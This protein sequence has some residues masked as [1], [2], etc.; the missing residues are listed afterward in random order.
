MTLDQLP[1]I[2]P[3]EKKSP[4]NQ[5]QLERSQGLDFDL[6]IVGGGIVGLT[7]ACALKDSGLR[8]ALIEAQSPEQTAARRQAYAMSLLSGRI[9]EG[10]GV[11]P[12]I[13]PHITHFQRVRLSDADY[14]KE[15]VFR[16]ED[17]KTK[18]VYYGAEHGVLI[19]ALQNCVRQCKSV[20]YLCPAQLIE[21]DYQP[22]AVQLKVQ[23]AGQERTLR[24]QLM[25]AADGARS[26]IRQQAGIGSMGWK[27]WQSCITAVLKP[28]KSHLDTAYERFWPD[29]PFAIL[30]L[31][32]NRCQIVWTVPHAKAEAILALP[33]EE[34]LA[35]LS[36][37]YGAQM[38]ALT[39]VGEPRLFKVQLMQ[40]NC[41]V[42][43]RLALMGDAA[44][45]CHPVG[46]Q[47]LNMGIRDAAA[48]S[49]VLQASFARGE[50]IGDL[51][52]LKRYERWRRRENWLVLGFTD[53]LNRCFSNTFL[54]L[55][56]VRRLGIHILQVALPIK[57]L[58]LR[59]M[60]GLFGRT[61][62]LAR[63]S[64]EP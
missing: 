33:R 35:Q 22:Q 11:W 43:P 41:Y 40:S 7:L 51:R 59:L 13:S 34:F 23:M 37:N 12:Q 48:L 47:G 10:I 50:D 25:V 29:G 61:P 2:A 8:V 4:L 46:G 14:P 20:S 31:P 1:E 16:P 28:E 18:A 53:F 44:H 45:C 36:H 17:L 19:T 52:A 63:H 24:A 62:N 57:R 3:Q 64:V 26:R 21:V 42:Q 27:Y 60:T 15:V 39:L 6:A 30:P 49:Q 55:V 54:P 5:T 32:G 58:M 9:F 56:I 38:G